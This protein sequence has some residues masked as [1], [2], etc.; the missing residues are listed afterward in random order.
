LLISAITIHPGWRASIRAKVF[1]PERQILARTSAYLSA[2]GPFVSVFKVREGSSL[3]LEIFLNQNEQNPVTKMH[4]KI[5]LPN[6]HDGHV[7]FQGNAT[8]LAISD[9]D[10]DGMMDVLAPTFDEQMNP[11]LNVYRFN[12]ALQTFEQAQPPTN[13]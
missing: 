11:R 1:P 8:N 3:F 6:S 4:Q 7:N 10:Q 12:A 2:Q 13:F 5:Q 9:I